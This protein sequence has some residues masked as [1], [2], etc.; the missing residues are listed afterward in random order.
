MRYAAI[1]FAALLGLA[2]NP[3]FAQQAEEHITIRPGGSSD[4]EITFPTHNDPNYL[5][6]GPLEDNPGSDKSEDYQDQAGGNDPIDSGAGSDVDSDLMPDN[7]G[8]YDEN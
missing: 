5:D 4:V 1:A 2:A 8:A 3:A 7:D 6:P